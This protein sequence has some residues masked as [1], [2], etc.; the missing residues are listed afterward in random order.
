MTACIYYHPEAYQTAGP[1]LMGRNA[2]GESFLRGFFRYAKSTHRYAQVE[3]SEHVKA[4]QAIL[5]SHGMEHDG[6]IITKEN[7]ERLSEP[8]VLYLPGP[9]LAEHAWFRQSYGQG[10]WSLCGITHT[11]ASARAMD[12]LVEL[13][14]APVRGGMH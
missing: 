4:W 2:A 12:A 8:G 9:G 10:A 1:K 11:T 5:K 6:V 14:S 13:I 7:L 3:S